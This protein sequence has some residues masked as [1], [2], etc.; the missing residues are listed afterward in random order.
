MAVKKK[1]KQQYKF[2]VFTIF[3]DPVD[4][5]TSRKIVLLDADDDQNAIISVMHVLEASG[6]VPV[7]VMTIVTRRKGA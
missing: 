1:K 7:R 3:Y 2:S 6:F 4:G 5:I